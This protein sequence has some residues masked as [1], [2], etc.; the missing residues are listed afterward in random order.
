MKV[1]GHVES[2]WRYPVKSMRGEELREAFLGFP[3][4][5]GDRIYAFHDARAPKGFPYLTGREQESMLQYRPAFRHAGIASRPTNLAEAQA[6]G[7]NPIYP[8][9]DDL[10]VDVETPSGEKLAIDDPRLIGMLG[11][12]LRDGHDLSLL[13]SQRALADC[14]PVSLI[15]I[16]TARRLSD[17]LETP[18]DKR[19]FRANIY[20]DLG[21]AAGFAEDGFVGLTLHIGDKARIAILRRDSR[22]KM[23]T[24]D[25]DTSQA[26]PQIM[27]HLAREH[28]GKAGVYAVVIV[29]G[30][31]RTGD[32]ILVAAS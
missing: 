30:T 25:P 3:G 31:I 13:R 18:I 6:T 7:A 10:I 21:P 22:C 24:L 5:F 8:S 32:E 27:K 9:L 12:G 1:V 14:S 17:E 4:V 28:E 16:Q 19:R 2:L 26:S 11:R 29:E 20:A 23:I 15:S